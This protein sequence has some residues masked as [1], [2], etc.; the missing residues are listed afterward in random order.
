MTNHEPDGEW[1]EARRSF[2]SLRWC[3]YLLPGSPAA[4]RRAGNS[5]VNQTSCRT[6]VQRTKQGRLLSNLQ[7]GIRYC[8]AWASSRAPKAFFS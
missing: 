7:P 5:P 2:S 3:A 8:I 4:P 6:E 1:G